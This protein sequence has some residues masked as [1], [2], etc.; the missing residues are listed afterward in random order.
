MVPSQINSPELNQLLSPI[1]G[2]SE[3]FLNAISAGQ[4]TS[5]EDIA[6]AMGDNTSFEEDLFRGEQLP[7]PNWVRKWMISHSGER[8]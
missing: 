2:V 6:R 5:A 7:P 1:A 4:I 8:R 3:D